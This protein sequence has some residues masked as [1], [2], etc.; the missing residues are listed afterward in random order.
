MPILHLNIASF[1]VQVERLENSKLR[2]RP[3]AVAAS[4]LRRAPLVCVS[5]EA[6][7]IGLSKGMSVGEAYRHDRRLIVLPPNPRLYR[8]VQNQLLKLAQ[9]FTPL[10]E[11][12]RLGSLFLDLSGTERLFGK[13]LDA[14][15]KVRSGLV[16]DLEL[17]PTLG[18]AENKLVSRI[19]AK[20][21][22]PRGLCDVFPGDEA[23]FLKPLEVELL[24]GIGAK[25]SGMLWRELGIRQIGDLARI[26][27]ALLSRL[28]G[29]EGLELHDKAQG[30]DRSEVRPPCQA[31]ALH[32]EAVLPEASNDDGVLLARLWGLIE[33]LGSQLRERNLVAGRLQLEGIYADRQAARCR[34]PIRPPTQS[35]F[36]LRKLCEANWKKFLLRRIAL[37]SLALRLEELG[38]GFEQLDWT[39]ERREARLL[40]A[41]DGL[42]RRYGAEVVRFARFTAPP[43]A[44][45][46]QAS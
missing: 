26:P 16:A 5:A 30:I 2:G 43:R 22:R 8:R 38:P 45:K 13:A 41:L 29:R 14:A 23:E 3:V 24:P 27:V 46:L 42:R 28:F 11:P 18:I 7:A 37:K 39:V 19:A 44:F 36:A 35:D 40:A 4:G 6:R 15:S 17:Q 31:P 1:A 21:A 10:Y 25:V 32:A 34:L 9:R 20:L 33:E 12:Q